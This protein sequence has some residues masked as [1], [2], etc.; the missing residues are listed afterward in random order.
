MF[1]KRC[2]IGVDDN[3]FNLFF[4]AP[5]FIPQSVSLL[6]FGRNGFWKKLKEGLF[7]PVKLLRTV[8]VKDKKMKM[9]KKKLF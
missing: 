7:R 1:Q 4:S 6:V 2:P 3:S 8:A 9:W 5:L